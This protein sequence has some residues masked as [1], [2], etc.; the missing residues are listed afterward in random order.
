AQSVTDSNAPVVNEIQFRNTGVILK[1]TPRVNSSGLVTMDIEQE[2][3]AVVTTE[4]VGAGETLTPTIS[5]RRIASTIAVQSGRMVLLGGL[6]S[7]QF[8]D[9]KKRVPL[10]RDVP[11]LGEIV[12]DTERRKA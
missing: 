7:E 3:S 12:G 5:Q 1:V 4:A 9:E 8:N 6:I 2:I 10:L 11:Y